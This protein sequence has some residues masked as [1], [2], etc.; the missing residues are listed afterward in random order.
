MGHELNLT[1]LEKAPQRNTSSLPYTV[2]LPNTETET[3]GSTRRCGLGPHVAGGP[4]LAL[5]GCYTSYEVFR[6][7]VMQS[8]DRP[9]LGHRAVD[10]A[11]N[12]TPYMFQSYRYASTAH[13]ILE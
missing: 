9:C 7:G 10:S 8:P 6:R 11:G 3:K 5:C 4:Q 12:A 13:I 2:V 1:C